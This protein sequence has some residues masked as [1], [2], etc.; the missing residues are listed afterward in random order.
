MAE[1]YG[2][3]SLTKLLSNSPSEAFSARSA[4]R[5][6]PFWA[7]AR[8]RPRANVP[9]TPRWT[10]PG[11]A[12]TG[13]HGDG[14]RWGFL[15][16]KRWDKPRISWK[17]WWFLRLEGCT[18][19]KKPWDCSGKSQ[20]YAVSS[21]EAWTLCINHTWCFYWVHSDLLAVSMCACVCPSWYARSPT[22]QLVRSL[23][24]LNCLA[25]SGT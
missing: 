4:P 6:R 23:L 18:Q 15:L 21:S 1:S 25:L 14:K 11:D 9:P 10:W 7:A 2:S 5:S 17:K 20:Q 3:F 12:E 13:Q 24:S 22:S 8:L 16:G 19:Y